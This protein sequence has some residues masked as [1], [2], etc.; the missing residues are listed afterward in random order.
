MDEQIILN[1]KEKTALSILLG[2]N[3]KFAREKRKF[4]Q[5]YSSEELSKLF[6]ELIKKINRKELNVYNVEKE[7]KKIKENEVWDVIDEQVERLTI[8]RYNWLKIFGTSLTEIILRKKKEGLN[9]E[10]CYREIKNDPRVI[11]FL[12]E[13]KRERKKIL[14]NLEISVHARYG[15]NNTSNKIMEEEE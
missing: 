13:K 10:E 15:E 14:N 8:K 12:Q 4:P 6:S 9:L 7:V 1:A 2:L 3:Q 5:T 11:D